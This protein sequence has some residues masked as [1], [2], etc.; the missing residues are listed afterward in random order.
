MK[1]TQELYIIDTNKTIN[2]TYYKEC[3]DVFIKD[4][5][6]GKCTVP[7]YSNFE[8][9]VMTTKNGF[10]PAIRYD[11]WCNTIVIFHIQ[12]VNRT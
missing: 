11:G 9:M 7:S 10:V 5:E 8:E 3:I 6:L 2:E 4:N 12:K 1:N